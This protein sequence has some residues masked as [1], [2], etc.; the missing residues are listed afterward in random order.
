MKSLFHY[1]SIAMAMIVITLMVIIPPEVFKTA[2]LAV[3]LYWVGKKLYKFYLSHFTEA[4][5]KSQ[6]QKVKFPKNHLSTIQPWDFMAFP[7]SRIQDICHQRGFLFEDEDT[8]IFFVW[9]F[10]DGTLHIYPK[11]PPYF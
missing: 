10:A 2:I 7:I 11:I 6:M 1:V 9:P 8:P 4:F 3:I 5:L